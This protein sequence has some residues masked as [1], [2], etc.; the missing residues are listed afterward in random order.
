MTLQTV[1]AD[2]HVH[3]G[4]IKMAAAMDLTVGN[5]L[6]ECMAR[7]GVGMVGIIDAAAPP[8]QT[9]LRELVAAGLVAPLPDGGLRYRDAA[10]LILGC[11]VEVYHG[12]PLHLLCYFPGLPELAEFSAWQ[13]TVVKN[14]ALSTQRHRATAAQVVEQVAELGGFVVPAHCFTPYKSILAAAGGVAPAIAP[15]LWAHVPAAEL[16]LSSDTELADRVPELHRFAYV[17]NSDAHSLPKIAREYNELHVAAPS[18]AELR[19]ALQEAGGRR[20]AANYGLD[21]RLGKYHRSYCLACDLPL[22]APA[23]VTAC[24]QNPAHRLELGVL[25]RICLLAEQGAGGPPAQRR[26][27]PPY[28]H[29]VPLQFVPGL[30]KK[31]LERLLGAF[32]T[33]MQ[34]LHRAAAAELA[35]VVGAPLAQRIEAARTGRLTVTAGSGGTYGKLAAH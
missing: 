29:Q 7:K 21:P 33:E 10:T 12:G 15:D 24:P 6:H 20:V 26:P 27:R 22:Y 8:A 32:G 3:L 19:L 11:E 4:G 23:P 14:P 30:G 25:D 5:I 1:Y 9:Q 28:V 31:A 34:V 17:T 35:E 13:R 18:F 2:L 16:G